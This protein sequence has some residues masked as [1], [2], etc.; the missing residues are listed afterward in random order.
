M[1]FLGHLFKKLLLII[2]PVVYHIVQFLCYFLWIVVHSLI[3]NVN[4]VECANACE[5]TKLTELA[6]RV[7][8]FAGYIVSVYPCHRNYY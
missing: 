2:K 5:Y 1:T 7:V 4:A 6:F 8:F 3:S